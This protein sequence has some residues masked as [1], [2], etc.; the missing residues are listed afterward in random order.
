MKDL[1]NTKNN[2]NKKMTKLGNPDSEDRVY[3]VSG[4]YGSGKSEFINNELISEDNKYLTKNFLK[5]RGDNI[6]D[7]ISYIFPFESQLQKLLSFKWIFIITTTFGMMSFVT[8]LAL[9]V[10]WWYG[11]LLI[12]PSLATSMIWILFLI[13]KSRNHRDDKIIV[14]EDLNRAHLDRDTFCKYII[15]ITKKYDK[16]KFIIES[17]EDIIDPRIVD[18]VINLPLDLMMYMNRF[19]WYKMVFGDIIDFELYSESYEIDVMVCMMNNLLKLFNNNIR[20]LKSYLN[21]CI[22]NLGIY[23]SQFV[24]YHDIFNLLYFRHY[25]KFYDGMFTNDNI[26][27]VNSPP[28]IFLNNSEL[29][30]KFKYRAKY[31]DHNSFIL[32]G[33]S[34][35]NEISEK[36]ELSTKVSVSDVLGALSDDVLFTKFSMDANFEFEQNPFMNFDNMSYHEKKSVW[37]SYNNQYFLRFIAVLS[38]SQLKEIYEIL[39]KLFFIV[40]E[41]ILKFDDDFLTNIKMKNMWEDLIPKFHSYLDMTKNFEDIRYDDPTWLY[42]LEEGELELIQKGEFKIPSAFIKLLLHQERILPGKNAKFLKYLFT[43]E[44][45]YRYFEFICDKS[46]DDYILEIDY[47]HRNNEAFWEFLVEWLKSSTKKTFRI[48]KAE[49]ASGSKYFKYIDIKGNSLNFVKHFPN[50]IDQAKINLYF[51]RI[52][53]WLSIKFRD[54]KIL[55]I[56]EMNKAKFVIEDDVICIKYE[57]QNE[58]GNATKSEKLESDLIELEKQGKIL[59]SKFP[60]IIE[61]QKLYVIKIISYDKFKDLRFQ[62]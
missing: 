58:K 10:G 60:S 35:V 6:D 12:L 23:N 25:Y 29:I 7:F 32:F 57:L 38:E 31:I 13:S 27:Y 43:P 44:S 42:D 39:L 15:Y 62:V 55:P 61:K 48:H 28:T 11:F 47:I 4:K 24:K 21:K 18:R 59:S 17:D 46:R 22:K 1:E 14:L 30:E 41:S 51:S 19:D 8:P 45:S 56:H 3:L 54:L 40:D 2:I 37:L 20:D 9:E 16:R 53:E 34:S 5:Y 50:N 52:N 36:I 33:N 49:H 26:F